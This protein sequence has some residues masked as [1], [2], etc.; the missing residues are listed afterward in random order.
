[1]AV[2]DQDV[3]NLT[4]VEDNLFPSFLA[5]FY[6]YT[7]IIFNTGVNPTTFTDFSG[8]CNTKRYTI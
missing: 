3:I 4:G 5:Q 8:L 7:N 1:M 6:I 2:N